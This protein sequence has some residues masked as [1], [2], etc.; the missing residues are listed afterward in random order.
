MSGAKLQLYTSALLQ[1]AL[2]TTTKKKANGSP[3]CRVIAQHESSLRT[4]VISTG[5]MTEL[6][7]VG[8]S[9]ETRHVLPSPQRR[10]LFWEPLDLSFDGYLVPFSKDRA[11]VARNRTLASIYNRHRDHRGDVHL[12]L[13]T[14]S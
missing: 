4:S 13:N 10:D 6:Y 12:I 7:G 1:P 5:R 3:Y 8:S 11:A 2:S 9:A 14:P